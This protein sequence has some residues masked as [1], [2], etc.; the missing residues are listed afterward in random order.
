[1]LSGFVMDPAWDKL[2]DSVLSGLEPD[3]AARRLIRQRLV[4]DGSLPLLRR[5]WALG[6]SPEWVGRLLRRMAENRR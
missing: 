4:A 5:V 6:G 2:V 1:M 3:G